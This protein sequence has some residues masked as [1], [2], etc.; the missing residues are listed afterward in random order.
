[1]KEFQYTIQDENGVHARPAGLLVRKSQS[2]KSDASIS[3]DEKRADLKRLFAVM[4]LNI[5]KGA[6]VSVQIS[7]VDEEN[8]AQELED[9][10]K[11]NL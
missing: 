1:M 10:M 5:K 9:F 8:A 4:G 3:Y 2:F 7:G 11:N 6:Q